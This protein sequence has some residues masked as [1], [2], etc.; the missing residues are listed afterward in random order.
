MAGETKAARVGDPLSI[1][2]QQVGEAGQ[3]REGFQRGGRLAEGKQP[4]QVGEA[5]GAERYGAFLE[6]KLG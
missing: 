2:Q 6:L 3:V 4:G 1:T 5:G